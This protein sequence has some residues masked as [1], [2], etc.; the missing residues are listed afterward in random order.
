M[1]RPTSYTREHRDAGHVG[2]SSVRLHT[3][4]HRDAWCVGASTLQLQT[5]KHRDAWHFIQPSAND[6]LATP[7]GAAAIW[8]SKVAST[9]V[10]GT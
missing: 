10:F 2:V 6:Q 4:K 7:R 5:S 9:E 1:W 8:Q 3:S